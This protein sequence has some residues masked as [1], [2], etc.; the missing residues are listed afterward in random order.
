MPQCLYFWIRN[1]IS[2]RELCS[3][4]IMRELRLQPEWSKQ[5][6]KSSPRQICENLFSNKQC[7]D[8]R[9]VEIFKRSSSLSDARSNSKKFG[10]GLIVVNFDRREDPWLNEASCFTL[11]SRVTTHKLE[12]AISNIH[13][14]LSFLST[15]FSQTIQESEWLASSELCLVGRADGQDV[16]AATLPKHHELLIPTTT[17]PDED[18]LLAERYRPS[19]E[20][21]SAQKGA[22]LSKTCTCVWHTQLLLSD[23]K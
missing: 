1:I 13:V 16:P 22:E 5:H 20:T 3:C 19:V 6:L 7:C 21:T 2:V 23:K 14:F 11:P 10:A 18:I 8:I 9:F 15:T 12:P 17:N 4:H